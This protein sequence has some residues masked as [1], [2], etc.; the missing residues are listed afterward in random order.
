MVQVSQSPFLQALGY[1]ILNSL[2]QFALLWLVYLLI[3][4]VVKLSS[5]NK[6]SIATALQFSG[7][8]WFFGTLIFYYNQCVSISNAGIN[9]F[10][11]FEGGVHFTYAA[12]IK[13][14][15]F[16]ALMRTEHFLPYLSVAYLFL[17]VVLGVKW[18]QSYKITQE[19]KNGGLVRMDVDQRLF[20]E[21][22]C[23]QLGIKRPVKVFLSHVVKSP[24]TIGFLKPIILVPLASINHLSTDQL[25]AVLLHELA[26]IKRFDYL[27]NLILSVIEVALFY[28]PF[29]QLIS[30]HIKR[31][32]ENSCDDWVLQYE[33]NAATYARALLQLATCNVQENNLAMHAVDKNR[34]L[35]IR[36]KRMIEKNDR[37]VNYRNQLVA[38]LLISAALSSVAWFTPV[39]GNK[40]A[41]LAMKVNEVKL[42]AAEPLVASVDNPFFN[43]VF[44]LVSNKKEEME[45]GLKQATENLKNASIKFHKPPPPVT[46]TARA[47]DKTIVMLPE[48]P[49]QYFTDMGSE[50]VKNIN[51]SNNF[52]WKFDT[53]HLKNEAS[54][55]PNGLNNEWQNFGKEISRINIQNPV[56]KLTLAGL[57]VEGEKVKIEI[58]KALLQLKT[59]AG[60][61]KKENARVIEFTR[62]A[63][64][65]AEAAAAKYSQ[66]LFSTEGFEVMNESVEKQFEKVN[67]RP[68]T[69]FGETT[70]FRRAEANAPTILYAPHIEPAHTYSY[71]YTDKPVSGH[72]VITV[73]TNGKTVSAT[74]VGGTG[75]K[76]ANAAETP[77]A[78]GEPSS[79]PATRVTVSTRKIIKIIRI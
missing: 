33:Y 72:G 77:K 18:I 43:P 34:T 58:E 74:I 25:E 21:R 1:A 53:V 32:R 75:Y 54:G 4:S 15:V 68:A 16:I 29:M 73:T 65:L 9:L 40:Q 45:K 6:Y 36:V 12:T 5:H 66:Q 41:E 14:N 76:D 78:V 49:P 42:Y 51:L 26:H 79:A 20:V 38:L 28:N 35:L 67:Y 17:L 70:Q 7:F 60:T 11:G 3:N 61:E 47:N 57:R 71:D 48:L 37:S 46:F 10:S 56:N 24:L 8:A 59:M 30:R 19:L 44:F 13:E 31:E 55:L 27:A 22:L 50:M 69:V 62:K 52:E 63:A 23:H 64:K 39:T 2:W